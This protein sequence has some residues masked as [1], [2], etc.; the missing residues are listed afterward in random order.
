MRD[1]DVANIT[2]AILDA[3]EN[4]NAVAAVIARSREAGYKAGNTG[5]LVHVN[6]GSPKKFT[7][8]RCALRGVD[9]EAAL[10]T[11]ADAYDG[12]IVPALAHIEECLEA[13]DYVDCL[14]MLFAT[15]EKEDEGAACLA[16]FSLY[17]FL[18]NILVI[19]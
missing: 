5:C 11:A 8:A 12:L 2:N 19:T 9:T 6:A 15:K 3:P 14:R 17:S 18:G 16:Y 1:S 13:D 4:T 10:K 7:D